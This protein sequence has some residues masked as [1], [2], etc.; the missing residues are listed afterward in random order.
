MRGQDGDRS[1]PQQR[2]EH[3]PCS[4]ESVRGVGSSE[5]LVEQHNGRIGAR[6]RKYLFQALNLC[7]KRDFPFRRES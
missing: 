7:K 2:L 1:A 5:H 4:E 3:R 6:R